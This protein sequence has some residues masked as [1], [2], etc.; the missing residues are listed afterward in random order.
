[1]SDTP[2][3]VLAVLDSVRKDKLSCYGY[4]ENETPTLDRLAKEGC[5][6]KRAYA[7][8]SWTVPSHASLFTG[9][10]PSKHGAHAGHKYLHSN[11]T[12]ARRL[13]S[14]GYESV[15]F[16]TNPWITDEF[17]YSSGF[18]NFFELIKSKI[19]Y[20]EASDPR[21]TNWEHDQGLLRWKERAEWL[22]GSNPWKRAANAISL[23]M[24]K[25]LPTTPAEEV[26][27]NIRKW[28]TERDSKEPFFMFIN[29]MD[30]HEPYRIHDRYLSSTKKIESEGLDL[31]WN[32][33][34]LKNGPKPG[35][36]DIIK[37][38]Y[39]ASI[40]YLDAQLH[41][42]INI[43][44]EQEEGNETLIIVL[45]DHGQCLGEHDYWGHGTFLFEE[46][47]HV[48][49]IISHPSLKQTPSKHPDLVTIADIPEYICE[50]VGTTLREK[51]EH[52]LIHFDESEA[53]THKP[54]IIAESYGPPNNNKSS[55]PSRVS[56][57]GYRV[58][59]H[60]SWRA[61][62]NLDTGELSI[63]KS[64]DGSKFSK[65]EAEK[66]FRNIEKEIFEEAN[67]SDNPRDETRIS[68][69]TKDRLNDLGYL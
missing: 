57:A 19:P 59:H 67:I 9:E 31:D 36:E 47:I 55:L 51:S 49:L 33:D 11:K 43:L 53:R 61:H 22:L 29:Y 65:N 18:D 42:L 41:S 44:E 48:P 12:L 17:G 40:S 34:S 26:N 8:G 15:A 10:I 45:G 32:L 16:S 6:F 58:I 35:D 46:L 56:R 64:R 21:E 37:S 13:S 66:R 63:T 39:D 62:R 69:T 28:L 14:I 52:T 5:L 1:M 50:Y 7:T 23:K 38:I 24:H 60:G 3:I 30:A 27:Q 68:D 4:G 25:D 2:N 20:T 54:T